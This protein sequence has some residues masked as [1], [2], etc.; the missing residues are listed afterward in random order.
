MRVGDRTDFN[1]ILFSI[2]TDGT[3]A[4]TEVMTQAIEIMI[5]QL[6]AMTEE[7]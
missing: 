2:E 3:L 6:Q 4:P 7:A 1:R 5:E